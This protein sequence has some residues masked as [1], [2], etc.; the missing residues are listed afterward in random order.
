MAS[1]R[2]LDAESLGVRYGEIG[3]VNHLYFDCRKDGEEATISIKAKS[4]ATRGVDQGRLWGT[5]TSQPQDQ[6]S[7]SSA[8]SSCTY[9]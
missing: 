4:S 5:S 1:H 7:I 3:S 6:V 8:E 2:H 9:C